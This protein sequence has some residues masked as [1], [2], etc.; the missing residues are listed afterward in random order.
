MSANNGPKYALLLA[1]A[2]ACAATPGLAANAC[3]KL[4]GGKYVGITEAPS[5]TLYMSFIDF[6][7]RGLTHSVAFAPRAKALPGAQSMVFPGS[8]QA[9]LDRALIEACSDDKGDANSAKLS[10]ASSGVATIVTTDNGK[11]FVATVAQGNDKGA[12]GKMFRTN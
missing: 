8:A 4:A 9:T 10:F 12:S 11:S 6:T 1:V 3:S 7:T 2:A 5:G